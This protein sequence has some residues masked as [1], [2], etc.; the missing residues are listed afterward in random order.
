MQSLV[1]HFFYKYWIVQNLQSSNCFGNPVADSQVLN[2]CGRPQSYVCAKCHLWVDGI[3]GMP[4]FLI[5]VCAWRC[6]RTAPRSP[7]TPSRAIIFYLFQ[8]FRTAELCWGVS[9]ILEYGFILVL[10][11]DLRCH[12]SYFFIISLLRRSRSYFCEC[13]VSLS[14]TYPRPELCLNYILNTD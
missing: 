4:L 6:S 3:I 11:T 14:R 12:L 5:N 1:S 2:L 8:W 13:P 9:P 10:S 7:C